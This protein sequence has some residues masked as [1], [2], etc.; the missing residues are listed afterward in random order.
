MRISS[1]AAV[2][3][4]LFAAVFSDVRAAELPEK[5]SAVKEASV[6]TQ[7]NFMLRVD[8]DKPDRVYRVG[9]TISVNVKAERDCYLYVLHYSAGE[10]VSCL[11][12]NKYQTD[13]HV[14]KGQQVT[15]PD[16]QAEFVFR[17]GEPCGKDVLQV[18]ATRKP[19]KLLKNVKAT[20]T[21]G[22]SVS[23]EDLKEMVTQLRKGKAHDW[24]EARIEIT[25]V[26]AASP[27]DVQKPR[28]EQ[29][30]AVCVGVSQYQNSLIP[31]LRASHQDAQR[32]AE[33]LKKQ[34]GMEDVTLLTDAQATRAAIQ[35]AIF[36]DLVARSKPG[37]TVFLYFSCHGGRAAHVGDDQQGGFDEYLVPFDGEMGKAETMIL[38]KLFARW[39]RELDGRKIGIILDNCYSGGCTKDVPLRPGAKGLG[40]ALDGV[41]PADFFGKIISR[42]K[43]VGQGNTVLLAACEAN[44][45]AWE[46]PDPSQG[47]VLT[48]HLLKFLGDATMGNKRITLSDAHQAVGKPVKEFVQKTFQAQQTPVLLDYAGDGIVLKP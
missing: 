35:Q 43:D 33:L 19:A 30:L 12:P 45:L 31:P 11:F 39:L 2:A 41:G 6:N 32:M 10:Q 17:I 14:G 13:N 46:M 20:K 36:K 42:A 1:I 26:A 18:I 4:T 29:R 47:S 37:D 16:P 5:W 15:V 24:A 28:Q 9:E 27:Q 44:Q 22:A 7:A 3:A 23:P 40:P 38:D 21:F 8:V 48:C 34:C 25:T